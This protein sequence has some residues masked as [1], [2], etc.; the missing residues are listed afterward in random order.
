M[1]LCLA[2]NLCKLCSRCSAGRFQVALVEGGGGGHPEEGGWV[3]G[4]SLNMG[5]QREVLDVMMKGAVMRACHSG[6][7]LVSFRYFPLLPGSR[8]REPL[9]PVSPTLAP[10]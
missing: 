8:S 6:P 5:F 1:D 3:G 10:A 9:S 2:K 4:E 7:R